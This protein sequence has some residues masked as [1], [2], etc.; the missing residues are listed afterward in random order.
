LLGSGGFRGF[1]VVGLEFYSS[2]LDEETRVISLDAVELTVVSE[3]H[4]GMEVEDDILVV[5]FRVLTKLLADV[6]V[7]T[8]ILLLC[9][10]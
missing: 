2:E 4:L 6:L 9:A 3:G 1:G 10:E 5:Y 7:Q 8:Y